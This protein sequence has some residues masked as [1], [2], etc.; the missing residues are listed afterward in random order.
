MATVKAITEVRAVALHADDLEAMTEQMPEI[1]EQL[2]AIAERR[3]A[4]N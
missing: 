3:R 4:G 1:V 2:H